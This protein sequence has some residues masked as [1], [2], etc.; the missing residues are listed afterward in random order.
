MKEE[1]PRASGGKWFCEERMFGLNKAVATAVG[2]PLALIW[3]HQWGWSAFLAPLGNGCLP[4]HLAQWGGIPTTPLPWQT[5]EDVVREQCPLMALLLY[6]R[7]PFG[8]GLAFILGVCVWVSGYLSLNPVLFLVLTLARRVLVTW[9]VIHVPLK[10]RQV[11]VSEW[12]VLLS[13]TVI[14]LNWIGYLETEKNPWK[15]PRWDSSDVLKTGFCI[16]LRGS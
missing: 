12:Y 1:C 6:Q 15:R 3:G 11:N 9:M 8:I 5:V 2:C 13:I 16:G 10:V 4:H 7:E 14:C